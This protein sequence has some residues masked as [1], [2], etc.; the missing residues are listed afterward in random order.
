MEQ[1]RKIADVLRKPTTDFNELNETIEEFHALM[2]DITGVM[3]DADENREN[4]YSNTGMALGTTWAAM[5][6]KDQMRT[7]KFVQ[8]IFKAIEEL[9]NKKRDTI[10]LLYA[11]TGPFASLL[12]P[13][14]AFY[15][16]HELQ[17]VL[18]EI[19]TNSFKL[20]R[21]VIDKLGFKEHVKDFVNADATSYSA[22]PDHD[23]DI[24]LSETMQR[25][26]MSEQQVPIM[27]N[28][29]SQLKPEAVMIPESISLEVGLISTS[30]FQSSDSKFSLEN[31]SPLGVFYALTKSTI[32]KWSQ[33]N[34]GGKEAFVFPYKKFIIT[35]TTVHKHKELIIL[36]NITIFN[37]VVL[38]I[39]ESGLTMPFLL[40]QLKPTSENRVLK[41]GYEI[42]EEPGITYQLE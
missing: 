4:I 27:I 26:L 20:M 8:G 23:I 9:K 6:I 31:Y 21:G 16:P 35:P 15:K 1:L 12:L 33:Y 3:P 19:N 13:V 11:G 24:L 34:K 39:N 29:M 41:I 5:C 38:K 42:N 40:Y 37:D 25:A 14:L 22:N 17:C 32:S 7:K 30:L 18:L 10:T 36:T 2:L 28:L